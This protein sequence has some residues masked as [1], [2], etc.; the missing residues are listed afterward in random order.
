MI[1]RCLLSIFLLCTSTLSIGVA[2]EDGI[3]DCPIAEPC[4]VDSTFSTNCAEGQVCKPCWFFT[5]IGVCVDEND[6]NTTSSNS[7][8]TPIWPSEQPPEENVTSQWAVST[9]YT[10]IKYPFDCPQGYVEAGHN[11]RCLLYHDRPTTLK[12]AHRRCL[13]DGG[14]GGGT[15]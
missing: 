7:S 14:A 10:P 11:H 2:D 13:A 12:E 1:L 6:S 5:T 9:T 15:G 4:S 8:V 3:L